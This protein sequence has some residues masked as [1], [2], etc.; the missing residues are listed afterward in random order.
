[1]KFD[2]ITIFP[3]FFDSLFSV[4]ILNRA[5][6]RG[7]IK[8]NTHNLRIYT[9]D[10]RRS[11][12]DRPYGGGSGMV[13]KPTPLAR[14]IESIKNEDLKSVVILTTP[15]GEVFSD[16]I[17]KE[18]SEFEQVIIICGRYEGVDERIRE[19]YVEREIS[20]GDY[21]LSGGE[22]AASVI[23]D[24]I[25]RFVPG[26]LG[27]EAS[28]YHDSFNECLLEHPQYTRPHVFRGKRVPQILLS[29]NHKAIKKWRRLESIT[30]T[31]SRKPYL[32]DRTNLT[33]EEI[34]HVERLIDKDPRRTKVYVALV[35]YPV[36]NKTFKKITTAFT[37]L[38]V[39]D[40]SRVCKTYGVKGFYLVQPVYEQQKLVEAVL[41]H[42]I[43]GPGSS[44]NPTRTDALRLVSIR[45]SIDEAVDQ[46]EK[47]EGLKPKVVVTDA[48]HRNC[49]I[50]Y[51]ELREKI[52]KGTEPYLIL[53]GTGWGIVNEVLESADYVLK[54]IVG[55]TNYN[56]LSVRSA[57]AIVLDRL[58]SI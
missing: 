28:P 11:V 12:D 34:N 36:Y 43:K 53:F 56:H 25:S 21:V 14:A 51:Q 47:Q 17:A 32:I 31:L 48:R 10:K 23:I 57:A 24:A 38:D 39:H 7:I 58:L 18:V 45:S 6:E 30:R 22:Y 27:N 2:V 8:I 37:N 4:G 33:F 50:G 26:V 49:T 35:H 42:W 9:R 3:Q 1:M 5:Q 41:S 55:Y 19:K 29:G 44:F 52:Q 40:M 13:F 15:H 54:P 46:I 16:R 20:I